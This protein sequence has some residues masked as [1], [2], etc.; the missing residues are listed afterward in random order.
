MKKALR[1][2]I[3]KQT[4]ETHSADLLIIAIYLAI[5]IITVLVLRDKK[6]ICIKG[7][8]ITTDKI[9]LMV[10][11]GPIALHVITTV[12]FCLLFICVIILG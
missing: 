8:E 4:M 6:T 11:L 5:I 1:R 2:C 12:W 10:L 7:H 9:Y 3:G